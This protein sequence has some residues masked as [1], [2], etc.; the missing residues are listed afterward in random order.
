MS[1]EVVRMFQNISKDFDDLVTA[2]EEFTNYNE[3]MGKSKRKLAR[4]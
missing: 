3:I 1:Y 4:K 2:F